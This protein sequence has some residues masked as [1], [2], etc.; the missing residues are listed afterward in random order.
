M[1]NQNKVKKNVQVELLEE[2]AYITLN[3]PPVNTISFK[4]MSDIHEALSVIENN[5]KIKAVILKG[6]NGHFMA[7]AELNEFNE[8]DTKAKGT[9][10]SYIGH[11]LM[12]RMES[13]PK[14]IIALIEGACLG[15]GMELAL[16]CHIRLGA[17][18]SV[19]GFP[20][21]TLGLIPG[22]G[23]TQRLPKVIGLSKAKQM[24]LT[25]AKIGAEKAEQLGILD[26][27][28]AND[29][30]DNAGK[31]LAEKIAQNGAIALKYCMQAINA[32]WLG[33]EKEGYRTE[34][35]L[36]GACFETEEKKERIEAF[37]TKRNK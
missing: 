14:P 5:D 1:T 22:A 13:F 7:G 20:E 10:T 30:L 32:G 2:I 9:E 25:G 15:G 34:A 3:N 21:V 29:E 23:G 17:M 18:N 4:T 12:D 8:I 16:A 28:Y 36:F 37:L 27:V 31:E 11:H 24:I 6:S 26:G 35:E 19:Y 33:S